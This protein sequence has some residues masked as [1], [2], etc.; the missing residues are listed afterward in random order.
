MPL[1][2]WTIFGKDLA[3]VVGRGCHSKGNCF[4]SL[5]FFLHFFLLLLLLR[6]IYLKLRSKSVINLGGDKDEF[7]QSDDLRIYIL[8]DMGRM[9]IWL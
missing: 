1:G 2:K 8:F 5:L 9:K 6:V 3:R 7:G 4:V